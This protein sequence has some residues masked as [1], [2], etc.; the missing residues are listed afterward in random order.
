VD[1]LGPLA[2]PVARITFALDSKRLVVESVPPPPPAPPVLGSVVTQERTPATRHTVWN[3]SPRKAWHVKPIVYTLGGGLVSPDVRTMA[4]W[5]TMWEPGGGGARLEYEF[6]DLAGQ[7]LAARP[8]V[9]DWLNDSVEPLAFSPDGKLAAGKLNTGRALGLFDVATG[10]AISKIVPAGDKGLG[11]LPGVLFSGDG[12]LL[13]VPLVDAT[14][15]AI[16]E[17]P[18]GKVLRSFDKFERGTVLALSTDGKALALGHP[19]SQEVQ[20]YDTGTGE[21]TGSWTGHTSGVNDLAFSADGKALFAASGDRMIHVWDPAAAKEIVRFQAHQSAVTVLALS[22][23]G[24]TLASGGA[25]KVAR[26]WDVIA[27][28]SRSKR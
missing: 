18:T 1:R 21:R 8:K 7:R 11:Q 2:G 5:R 27:L 10:K 26:L 3:L 25:D 20:V 15:L 14:T 4:V 6:H 19:K 22:P 9:W 16:C 17:V 28:S 24:Q 13:A 12:T 23:D